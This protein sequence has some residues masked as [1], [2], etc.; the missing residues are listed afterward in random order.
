MH[1]D[2]YRLRDSERRA[3]QHDRGRHLHQPAGDWLGHARRPGAGGAGPPQR[4]RARR[5]QDPA[6]ADARESHGGRHVSL[7]LAPQLRDADRRKGHEGNHHS[8]GDG[9]AI[10]HPVAKRSDKDGAPVPPTGSTIATACRQGSASPPVGRPRGTGGRCRDHELAFSGGQS[11]TGE[12]SRYSATKTISASMSRSSFA[13]TICR[14]SFP[15]EVLQEAE[16]FERTIRGERTGAPATI[17]GRCRSSP[18]MARPRAISM[19]R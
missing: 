18:S 19:M 4:R 8:A 6:R 1:R 17:T 10:S 7:R 12:W 16:Q 3:A 14:T 2:G 9:A 13:S 5:R 15:V 11:A